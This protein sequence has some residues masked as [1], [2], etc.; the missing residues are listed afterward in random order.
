M[1]AAL[2]VCVALPGQGAAQSLRSM[3]VPGD[4]AVVIAPRGASSFPPVPEPGV[5]TPMPLTLPPP[6]PAAGV[7]AGVG[8]AALVP[9]LVPLAAAVLLGATAPGSG[10]T[11]T[12]P[13]TTR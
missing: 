11:S 4:A 7:A 5:T 13:A 6:V 2:L 1:L 9:A 10:S 12:A 3:V 8:L